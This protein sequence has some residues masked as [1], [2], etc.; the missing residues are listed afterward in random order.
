MRKPVFG[1]GKHLRLLLP[2]LFFLQQVTAQNTFPINGVA[3]PA[4]GSYA[5]TNATIV[6][7]GQ[8]TL[9][10]ATLVIRDGKITAVG[11]NITVPK[12]AVQVDCKGKYIY[13]SFI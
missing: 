6:K 5:F 8:T 4:T 13:P 3:S 7:D 1:R 11:T 2:A 9:A 12:D 10:N